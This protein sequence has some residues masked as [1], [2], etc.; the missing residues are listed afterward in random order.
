MKTP[1]DGSNCYVKNYQSPSS[2]LMPEVQAQALCLDRT[3]LGYYRESSEEYS[4]NSVI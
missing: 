3:D 4:S 2:G 1:F